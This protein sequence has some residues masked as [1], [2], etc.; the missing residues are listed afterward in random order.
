MPDAFLNIVGGNKLQ[1]E[2]LLSLLKEK[3]DLKGKCFPN[4]ESIPAFDEDEPPI[5]QLLLLDCKSIYVKTLWTHI[6]AWN[7][8]H[9]C[10]CL[11]VLYNAES[12]SDLQFEKS[13]LEN[14]IQD[15]FYHNAPL[16][17][18]SKGISA[19]LKG[20]IWYSRKTMNKL[21][22]EKRSSSNSLA[23]PA[24]YRLTG[25]EKQVLVCIA[26]GYS[27][28]DISDE[29]NISMHTVKTHIYNLY[30]KINA[31]NRLQATLWATKYL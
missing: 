25:R 30:K 28:K 31:T 20:D 10:P 8:S 21:L 18:I 2:L 27:S 6:H 9:S 5:S 1:N 26:S 23:H 19:V 29:L 3:T 14:G 24:V 16:P 11:S 13:A 22:I 7:F 4:L 17:L 15:I 12:E